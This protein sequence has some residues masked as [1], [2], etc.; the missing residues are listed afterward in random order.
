MRVIGEF[1]CDRI[2]RYYYTELIGANSYD[3][4]YVCGE[5]YTCLNAEELW[6]YGK[7]ADLFGWH[8]SD[9]KIYDKPKALSEFYPIKPKRVEKWVNKDDCAF[10]K[11][12]RWGKNFTET[13]LL[14][15]P[16]PICEYTPPLERPP[17]SW[18]KVEDLGE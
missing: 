9:L 18:C 2:D 3:E 13:C 7:G 8:I 11:Y 14:D 17:Q 10:C 16:E 15:K 5:G 12:H 4:G 1:V 6:E